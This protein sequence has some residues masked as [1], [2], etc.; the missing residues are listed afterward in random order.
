[1]IVQLA[2]IQEGWRWVFLANPFIG[3]AVLPVAL[4][5]LPARHEPEKHGPDLLG[6]ILLAAVLLL[7]LISVAV[8]CAFGLPRRLTHQQGVAGRGRREQRPGRAP[9]QEGRAEAA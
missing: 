8:L 9:G 3:A 5:L 1:M 7:E 4:R 6:N 2:G